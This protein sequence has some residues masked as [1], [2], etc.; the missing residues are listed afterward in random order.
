MRKL[1]FDFL[2]GHAR[3]MGKPIG[4]RRRW[5]RRE[6]RGVRKESGVVQITLLFDRIPIRGQEAE[7]RD[8]SESRKGDLMRRGVRHLN[9]G[10]RRGR[11][12]GS[13]AEVGGHVGQSIDNREDRRTGPIK[14]RHG[15]AQTDRNFRMG[16]RR[17]SNRRRKS[18]KN[19]GSAPIRRGINGKG[20]RKT[21]AGR[22]II[23]PL[24]SIPINV[25]AEGR[26]SGRAKNSGYREVGHHIENARSGR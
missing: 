18:S 10:R 6:S 19:G 8:R 26:K 7:R 14:S 16:M 9:P 17:N 20:C 1:S 25:T 23:R 13:H 12:A 24:V 2:G 22:G 5:G 4:G 15:V 21:L 11:N 3:H